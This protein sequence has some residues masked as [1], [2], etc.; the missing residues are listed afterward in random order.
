MPVLFFN[1]FGFCLKKIIQ[2]NPSLG[3]LVI[4]NASLLFRHNKYI[5]FY[6]CRIKE[7]KILQLVL[8]VA[9]YKIQLSKHEK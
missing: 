1:L 7:K 3:I 6:H 8:V 2:P 5:D 9:N 4:S